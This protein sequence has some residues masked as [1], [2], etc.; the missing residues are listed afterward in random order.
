[1]PSYALCGPC[2]SVQNVAI[3]LRSCC[4][5]SR[6]CC[7]LVF[8]FMHRR[9]CACSTTDPVVMLLTTTLSAQYHADSCVHNP[10][11]CADKCR[12]TVRVT[13]AMLHNTNTLAPHHMLHLTCFGTLTPDASRLQK[14]DISCCEGLLFSHM[15]KSFAHWICIF[16]NLRAHC[17]E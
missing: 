1:M 13:G 3:M 15:R 10:F 6:S 2:S 4:D 11:A 17:V 16:D 7:D 14:Q 5:L 12:R 9:M 8:F